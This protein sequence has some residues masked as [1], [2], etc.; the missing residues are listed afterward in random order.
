MF[1]IEKVIEVDMKDL[2]EWNDNP[3]N[4]KDVPVGELRKSLEEN[5]TMADTIAIVPNGTGYLVIDGNRRLRIA[6]ELGINGKFL[7]KLYAKDVDKVALA[8]ILNGVGKAWNRQAFTQFVVG[9]PDRIDL[10]PKQYRSATKRMYELLGNDFR[11]F[12]LNCRPNAYDWGVQL[13]NYLGKGDDDKFVKKTVL[14]V[15]RYKMVREVRRAIDTSAS[16]PMI[17]RA[18]ANDKILKII[19]TSEE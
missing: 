17:E 3:G 6:R 8:I 7:A 15:G 10:I 9:H 16:K 1:K 13:A 2:K 18:I 12:A 11:W 4:R 14:W 5:G 19:L